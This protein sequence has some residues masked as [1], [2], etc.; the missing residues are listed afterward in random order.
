MCI[1]NE[2]R[3]TALSSGGNRRLQID[4]DQTQLRLDALDLDAQTQRQ[5][6]F[7]AALRLAVKM[8]LIAPAEIAGAAK[9]LHVAHSYQTLSSRLDEPPP[10]VVGDTTACVNTPKSELHKNIKAVPQNQMETRKRQN[11]INAGRQIAQRNQQK[12]AE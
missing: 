3:N 10:K 9:P 7:L 11:Q 6:L 5:R 1:W 12:P 8:N 4:G 2:R